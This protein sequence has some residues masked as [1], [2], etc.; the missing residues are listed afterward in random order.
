[1]RNGRNGRK[2]TSLEAQALRDREARARL[3]REG[4]DGDNMPRRDEPW[5]AICGTSAGSAAHRRRGERPCRM[6][7]DSLRRFRNPM[8]ET[9]PDFAETIWGRR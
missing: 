5:G 8:P 7:A 2:M 1:M 6:C 3:L 4:I 9:S